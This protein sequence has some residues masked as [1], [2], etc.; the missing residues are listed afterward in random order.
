MAHS[1]ETKAKIRAAWVERR[2]TFVPP[3]AGK[4]HTPET[5]AKMSAAAKARGSNRTGVKHTAETR[6][7]ISQR[8][9]ERTPRGEACHSFKDGRLTERRG[10][11]FSTDYKRWRFDVF[12]R[13]DFA[14]RHCGDDRGGN[15]HAHHIKGF[16]DH[17]ELRLSVDNGITLCDSCHLSLHRGEWSL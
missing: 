6:A 1:E 4:K 8:T 13:D 10:E 5:R 2:K 16:A 14:C 3:M 7:L 11:R 9:R 15:L 17:P 12:S